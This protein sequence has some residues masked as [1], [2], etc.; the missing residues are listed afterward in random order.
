ME[1]ERILRVV[2]APQVALHAVS[3]PDTRF[4]RSVSQ[5]CGDLG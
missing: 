1:R 4:G 2:D 3:Q 5:H